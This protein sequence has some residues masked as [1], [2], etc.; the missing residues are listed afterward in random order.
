LLNVSVT[1]LRILESAH[2][3]EG[4]APYLEFAAK[5]RDQ[6][7]GFRAMLETWQAAGKAVWGYGANAKGAVLLQAAGVDAGLL[8]RVV[9]DTP[10]K[11]GRLMPGTDIPITETTALA[12]PD[13]LVLLSWN[14]A[15][16]LEENARKRG[17]RGTI[18][19]PHAQVV[20]A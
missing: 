1:G 3:Q 11:W 7:A 15:K 19:L 17:F 4:L 8:A 10:G 5:S 16:A 2:F 14:N 20:D 12:F 13:V 9:D 6:I 18:I